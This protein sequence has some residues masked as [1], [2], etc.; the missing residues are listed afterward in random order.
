MQ[1]QIGFF[2]QNILVFHDEFCTF[3]QMNWTEN[4]SAFVFQSCFTA[5]IEFVS[6]LINFTVIE[7]DL[8]WCE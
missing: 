2:K 1:K 5:E 6:Y 7:P 3:W 8:N 4:N